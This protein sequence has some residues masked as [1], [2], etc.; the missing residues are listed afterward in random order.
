MSTL[1]IPID[2]IK[3]RIPIDIIKHCICPCIDVFDKLDDEGKR[4]MNVIIDSTNKMNQLIE[5]LLT[6]SRIGKQSL[7]QR[8]FLMSQ[9]SDPSR[10]GPSL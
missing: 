4:L 5:N 2:I 10:A 7:H 6:F 1:P 3:H 8:C 9:Y